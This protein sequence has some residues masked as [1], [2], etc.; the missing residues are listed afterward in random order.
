MQKKLKSVCDQL[1][2]ERDLIISEVVSKE[3][4]ESDMTL[5]I[6]QK[7]ACEIKIYSKRRLSISDIIPILGDFG[8]TTVSEITYEADG[9]IFVTKLM[10][11]SKAEGL[12]VKN[13]KNIKDVLLR[14]LSGE[15][16]SGKLLG[17]VY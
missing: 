11:D 8:F 4:R 17:L 7:A 10:L 14:V 5:Q 2:Q 6:C 16:E 15:I 3:L 13:A 12:L 9:A 1:I